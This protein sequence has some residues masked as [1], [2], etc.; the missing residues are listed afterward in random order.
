MKETKEYKGLYFSNNINNNKNSNKSIGKK[1]K[2]TFFENG[3]HFKYSSL[4]NELQKLFK[5]QNYSLPKKKIK[6]KKKD[7]QNSENNK[8]TRLIINNKLQIIKNKNIHNLKV[9]KV[10]NKNTLTIT[11]NN[12]KNIKIN[13]NNNISKIQT[14][15]YGRKSNNNKYSS[16][17]SENAVL[18]NKKYENTIKNNTKNKKSKIFQII[19]NIKKKSVE[20]KFIKKYSI[21]HNSENKRN[22]SSF[23]KSIFPAFLSTKQK[24]LKLNNNDL[25]S[26]KDFIKVKTKVLTPSNKSLKIK[27]CKIN[28]LFNIETERE[29]NFN[30]E[31]N[32]SFII[33]INRNKTNYN[34]SKVI[35]FH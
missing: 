2:K 27:K 7:L 20:K 23:V 16:F 19:S 3:A 15:T 13:K 33:N 31:I 29:N 28:K 9:K 14:I 35:N 21:I 22:S 5:K 34:S 4:Y 26:N 10:D 8:K 11:V 6:R 25:S 32:S 1:L 12:N 30:F 24:N 18:K 17:N